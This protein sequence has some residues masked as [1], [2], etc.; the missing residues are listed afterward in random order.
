M[1]EFFN[2]PSFRH[3]QSPQRG[4]GID[5]DGITHRVQQEPIRIAVGI[6]KRALEGEHAQAAHLTGQFDL[7]RADGMRPANPPGQPSP[8]H[9]EHRP[10]PRVHA[11]MLGQQR[12]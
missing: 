12:Q 4:I 8:L 9:F 5:G 6:G 2:H 7:G 3:R 11:E 10:D 1:R